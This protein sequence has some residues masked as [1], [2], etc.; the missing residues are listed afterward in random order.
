VTSPLPVGSKPNA[1]AAA[2]GRRGQPRHSERAANARRRDR[3][4]RRHAGLTTA[5]RRIGFAVV[6]NGYLMTM[7]TILLIIVLILVLT[8]GGLGLSRRR[9]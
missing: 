5:I 2:P 6:Q 8:G 9:R 7:L 4:R 1:R 3:S